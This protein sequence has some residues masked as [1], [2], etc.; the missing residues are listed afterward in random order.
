M[1][2]YN[3]RKNYKKN[4]S[5]FYNVKVIIKFLISFPWWLN[6]IIASILLATPMIFEKEL[7]NLQFPYI[8][9]EKFYIIINYLMFFLSGLFF[10][11]SIF[12]FFKNVKENKLLKDT[13]S[14]QNLYKLN[15]KELED[16]VKA[17][18]MKEGYKIKERG[19]AQADGGVDLEAY[20][21]KEKVIVQCKQWK[22]NKVGVSIV[23]EMFGVMIHEKAQK[24]YII[25]CG[26]FTKDAKEFAK[27]KPIYLIHGFKLVEMINKNTIE[28]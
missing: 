26:S 19:G 9:K 5:I 2:K 6:C 23:R 1:S 4:T 16:L 11:F 18:F 24:V 8:N 10:I 22:S 12:S 3:K 15:W 25:T 7:I 20:K 14:I 21:N 17:L 27:G 13:V 28:V